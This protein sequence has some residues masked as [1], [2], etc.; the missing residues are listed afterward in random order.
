[1]LIHHLFATKS[2]ESFV[3]SGAQTS[4]VGFYSK[5]LNLLRSLCWFMC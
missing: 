3:C 2:Q 4:S 5:V 1:M